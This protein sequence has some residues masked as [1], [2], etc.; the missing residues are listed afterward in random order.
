M[1]S[2]GN[3]N[4]NRQMSITLRE[5]QKHFNTSRIVCNVLVQPSQSQSQSQI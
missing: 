3:G 5:S 1:N 4:N 2:V